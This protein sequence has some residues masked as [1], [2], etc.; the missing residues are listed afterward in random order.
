MANTGRHATQNQEK[1]QQVGGEAAGGAGTWQVWPS[2]ARAG[3][4]RGTGSQ[5]SFKPGRRLVFLLCVFL[6]PRPSAALGCCRA[7]LPA[8][9]RGTVP[10]PTA[11]ARWGTRSSSVGAVWIVLSP[12]LPWL[13]LPFLSL[14]SFLLSSPSQA[15]LCPA[16][17]RAVGKAPGGRWGPCWRSQPRADLFSLCSERSRKDVSAS[18]PGCHVL[19]AC[20]CC[21]EPRAWALL[22]GTPQLCPACPA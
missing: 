18:A 16:S 21:W 14:S 15:S 4:A 5:V 12:P 19:S 8:P 20:W 2:Q 13:L 7:P 1:R 11:A 3:R 10:R 6:V 9:K 22:P 17:S